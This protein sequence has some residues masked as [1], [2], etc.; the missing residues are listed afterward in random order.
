MLLRAE[1]KLVDFQCSFGDV[2][3][4][5]IEMMA[6]WAADA[7]NWLASMALGG[8]GFSPGSSLWT[9]AT[10]EASQWL[11]MAIFVMFITC[12][13]AL[14]G[15]AVMQRPD[16]I[17]RAL[18]ATFASLPAFYFSY[19]FIGEGLKVID[20]F[21]DGILARLTGVDGFGQLIE[22]LFQAEATYA[23]A[24]TL[25]APPVGR[26]L[27]T[28]IIMAIGIFFVMGAM[29]FRDFVLMILIAFG[30][31]AFAL[32]PARG[33]SDEWFKR[34]L[35]AVTAM[36]LA[37]PLILGTLALIMAGFRDTDSI[38][39]GEGLS[40]AIGFVIAAFMPVLAYG[41]FQFMGGG[42]GGDDIGQRAAGQSSQKTQQLVSSVSRRIPKGGGGGGGARGGAPSSTS[43][44]STSSTTTQKT[45]TSDGG[46]KSPQTRPGE[47][48]ASTGR[49][50][51][52]KPGKPSVP[53]R[54]TGE[55][56]APPKSTS[57]PRLTPPPG[58]RPAPQVP[59]EP[60]R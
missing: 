32:M 4:S 12:T 19:F 46:A 55:A 35:S 11:G 59:R 2:F 31:L 51:G 26:M 1:D 17:K 7:I 18:L 47:G 8:Q 21:S 57:K 45:S 16:T 38:W 52:G 50:D 30:P 53:P 40:L 13:V 36:A 5:G 14:A 27:I 15:G 23:G 54:S 29:A 43:R 9:A 42:G 37:R 20:E 41:F 49:F 58:E 22:S 24:A 3:C 34:W 33:A 39:S 60:R 6:G 10:G 48:P 44:Q 28:I 56:P 25:A